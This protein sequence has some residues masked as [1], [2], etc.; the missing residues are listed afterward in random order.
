MS[1]ACSLTLEQSLFDAVGRVVVSLSGSVVQRLLS[2]LPANQT[3]GMD[4]G[5]V[6]HWRSPPRHTY[7]ENAR[8][9]FFWI[10]RRRE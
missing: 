4:H 2:Q 1:E 8:S 10:Y 7:P 5:G 3:G 6:W 9:S